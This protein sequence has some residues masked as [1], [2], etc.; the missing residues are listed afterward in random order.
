M[1][2]LGVAPSRCLTVQIGS[3]SE[4]Q[5]VVAVVLLQHCNIAA[6]A[7]RSVLPPCIHASH[8]VTMQSLLQV[9]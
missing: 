9:L 8:P 1:T 4:L 2:C 7:A 3:L 6:D 5:G